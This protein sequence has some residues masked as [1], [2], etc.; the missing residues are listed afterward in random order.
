MASIQLSTVSRFAIASVLGSEWSTEL[1]PSA[2]TITFNVGAV[3][4][5]GLGIVKSLTGAGDLDSP[6]IFRVLDDAVDARFWLLDVRVET[7]R[8]LD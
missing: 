6:L 4:S 8:K 1:S 5:M 7:D 3:F 2:S